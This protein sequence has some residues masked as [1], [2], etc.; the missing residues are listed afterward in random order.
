[1]NIIDTDVAIIG[2][3]TAGLA[4]Y[5]AAVAAGKQALLIESGPHG[6]TCARVGCMPSKL[7]IAAAEAAHGPAKW[8]EFGLRL[9]GRVLVDGVAVM[10]RVQRERDRFVGFVLDA[11]DRIPPGDRLTGKARFTGDRSL[12]IDGG[13]AVRFRS[14]VIATGSAPAIPGLLR[15][16]ADRLVVNDDVFAWSDLPRSAAV[17]GPGVI[18]LELGQALSRLGVDISM[19]GRGGYVGPFSDPALRQYAHTT[20]A[21]EFSLDPD[22]KVENITRVEGG[23]RRRPGRTSGS[24]AAFSPAIRPS[25]AA[26]C[27]SGRSLLASPAMK[28]VL[29]PQRRVVRSNRGTPAGSSASE[30][31]S[32]PRS[33]TLGVRPVAAMT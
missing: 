8:N 24:A 29:V 32:R 22:A 2:A 14:A 3:G 28:I 13:P 17:F 33:R 31:V 26:S 12:Q 5:R 23:V 6:T 25:S 16:A 19:V 30:V 18:G 11:V 9:E 1:M 4:A 10:A 21:A 27:S 15:D 7:L 20:F